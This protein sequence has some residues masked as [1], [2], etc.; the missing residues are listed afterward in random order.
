MSNFIEV[1]KNALSDETCDY[2]INCFTEFKERFDEI[3]EIAY[4]AEYKQD[5]K[6]ALFSKLLI[7]APNPNARE[8]N[9]F[10]KEDHQFS[11]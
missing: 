10:F 2:V 5:V 1:Y 4:G 11:S 8:I 3:A 9:E 6:F 7:E